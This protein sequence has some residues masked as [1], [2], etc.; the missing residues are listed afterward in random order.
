MTQKRILIA[1]GS[2][3]NS[4]AE[5]AG[6]LAIFLREERNLNVSLYNLCKEK[7]NSWPL[8]EKGEFEGIIVGTGIR[9]GKWT[10]EVSQF[11]KINK[12]ELHNPKT[13]F[14]FFISCGYASDPK[15]YPIAKKQFIL[16]KFKKYNLF[17]KITEAFGGVFD[18]SPSS[19]LNSLDKKILRWGAR[20]LKMKINYTQR[21]DYRDWNKVYNF[22]RKFESLLNSF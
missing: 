3:Y 9:I 21:N 17:P 20:D 19:N 22:A 13:I 2:R 8:L 15:Y 16:A 14:G 7:E 5:T 18:F 12:N 11:I 1:Y 4:T 10:K 6:I